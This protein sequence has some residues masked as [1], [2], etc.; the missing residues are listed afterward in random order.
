MN[1]KEFGKYLKERYEVQVKWYDDRSIL[2]KRL[3]YLFQIP[4]IF[5]SAIIP[6][7]AV[8]EEK[9]ITVI[10]SAMVAVFIGIS[11]FCK[12]E[13]KW[14]NYRTTCE[15]LRKELYYYQ[16][17]INDYKGAVS[18][19]DLFVQRVESTISTEH[20]KWLTIEKTKKKENK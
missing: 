15:T 10:L 7:F 16:S 9:W 13:E 6:I 17:K 2:Y 12:F 8:L 14:H 20:T 19:E 11:N 4:T 5:V 1:K 3:N 18:P